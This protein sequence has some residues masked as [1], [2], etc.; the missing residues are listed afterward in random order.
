MSCMMVSPCSGVTVALARVPVCVQ[1]LMAQLDER[2][3]QR[4]EAI[5]T[6]AYTGERL[7]Y[8]VEASHN[9]TER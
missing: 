2:R 9:R 6:P 7:V 8:P 3:R 5:A 1:D 4:E